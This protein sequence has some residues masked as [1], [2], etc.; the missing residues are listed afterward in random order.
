MKDVYL[1]KDTRPPPAG[2]RR[3]PRCDDLI[4][5]EPTNMSATGVCDLCRGFERE[6]PEPLGYDD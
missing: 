2:E 6:E 4:P 1:P 5:E 3:C